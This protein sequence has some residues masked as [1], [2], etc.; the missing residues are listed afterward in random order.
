M[1]DISKIKA[2]IEEILD[3][4][5]T[6]AEITCYLCGYTQGVILKVGPAAPPPAAEEPAPPGQMFCPHCGKTTPKDAARCTHC[7]K[8][9]K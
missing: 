4:K 9:V 3:R 5:P 6:R 8:S 2:D 1:L 7:H